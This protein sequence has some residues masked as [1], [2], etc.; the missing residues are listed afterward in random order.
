MITACRISRV[1]QDLDGWFHPR[2]HKPATADCRT[3]IE[4][5]LEPLL[6]AFAPLKTS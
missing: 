5:K 4:S 3:S 2:E 6:D 1:V